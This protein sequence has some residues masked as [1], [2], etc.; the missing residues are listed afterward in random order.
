MGAEVKRLEDAGVDRIQFDVMD[1][2]FVPNLTFGPEMIAAC[3]K[4]TSVPFETQL[5]VSQ[6]NVETMLDQYVAASQ[7]PNGEEGVVIVHAEAQV[8]LHRTLTKI[9]NLGGSPSVALNPGTPAEM[10]ENVLDLVDHVLVMTVNP[11]FGGQKYIPTMLD[12]IR[13]IRKWGVDRGLDF[14]IEVDGGIKANW[15][16]AACAEAGANCFIAG[17]GLF[18][19]DDMK[20]GCQELRRIAEQ[21][22]QGK[23]LPEGE[24]ISWLDE[25]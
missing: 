4:Y 16:I 17:S 15:T 23:V 13:K 3:R 7:G 20:V 2:N 19:Y 10:I 8:H 9:R 11:G 18:A 1:G 12:K 24:P 5:M 6:Y 21:A 25:N 22:Q 14:D